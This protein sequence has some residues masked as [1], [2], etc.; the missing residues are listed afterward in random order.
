MIRDAIVRYAD[1]PRPE[2]IARE[3][4]VPRSVRARTRVVLRAHALRV[5]RWVWMTDYLICIKP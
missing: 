5:F 4:L 1:G 2:T 3:S